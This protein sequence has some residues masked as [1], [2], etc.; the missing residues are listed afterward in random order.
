MLDWEWGQVKKKRKTRREVSRNGR[1]EVSDAK[2]GH[3]EDRLD[4]EW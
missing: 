3:K 2:G 4:V 1:K